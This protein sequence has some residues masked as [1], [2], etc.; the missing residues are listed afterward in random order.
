M[1]FP[2]RVSA[3][4]L[5]LAFWLSFLVPPVATAQDVQRIA[6]IVNDQV[7]S[8]YDL[9]Q[10]VKLVVVTA[11][12][13]PTPEVVER[14]KEQVLPRLIEEELKLQKAKEFEIKIEQKEIDSAITNIAKRNNMS[15]PQ[16][17]D[18]LGKSGINAETLRR[19]IA[20][21]NAWGVIIRG[22]FAQQISV[23]PEEIDQALE[24]LQSGLDKPQ[25]QLLEIFLDV[26]SSD[27]DAQVRAAAERLV[28]QMRSGEARF[29]DVA[30]QFSQSSSAST[31][32]DVGWVSGEQLP[33]EVSRFVSQMRPGTLSVPVRTRGGY[34]IVALR[35]RRIGPGTNPN[36]V[37]LT[38]KQV[39]V[40]VGADAPRDK[41]MAAGRLAVELTTRKPTCDV[42][43]DILSANSFLMGADLGEQRMTNLTPEFQQAV[44]GL[45]TGEVT[46]PVRS[47]AGFHILMICERKVEG[48]NLPTREAIEDQLYN[49]Q[50]SMVARRYLTDLRRDATVELR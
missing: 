10:R 35:D 25:Y 15:G 48:S 5:G 50:L 29:Q 44:A 49:Q 9:E 1:P 31:G 36:Q 42:Y 45:S 43:D 22:R 28:Q 11:G 46:Q 34:Y 2:A 37:K 47:K 16:I 19:Q 23:S 14:V 26:E 20:A 41:L 7:I 21:D 24:Q 27:Q 33:A 38:L 12:L 17:L 40:P 6:A 32:G 30:R 13:Q 39:V 8:A 3:A 4:A 18:M